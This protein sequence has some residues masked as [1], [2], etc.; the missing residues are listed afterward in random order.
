MLEPPLTGRCQCGAAAYMVTTAPEA[1]YV[2]HCRECQRQS[3]SAFG[4]SIAV[5]KVGFRLERGEVRVWSR[6]TDSG[7]VLHC[8]FCAVC[9][10][11]L[12]HEG[13]DWDVLTVKGEK[14][15]A[16]GEASRFLHRGIAGRA[17]ER[18][19]QLAE[20][21]EVKGAS[22][23]HGLLHIDLVRIIPEAMKPR[24]IEIATGTA[25]PNADRRQI[26]SEKRA[27]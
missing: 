24:R 8:H 2:C 19:F 6:G 17:F 14:S 5:A 22:L 21:V 10:S 4:V 3:A 7:R 20:H 13:P 26:D 18:R 15:E 27:A 1:V 9:G 16:E 25:L 23:K 12:W 11:R